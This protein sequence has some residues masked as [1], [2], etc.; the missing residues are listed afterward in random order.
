MAAACHVAQ[1]FG[2]EWRAYAARTDGA[3]ALRRWLS[4][5][6]GVAFILF[7]GGVELACGLHRQHVPRAILEL[8]AAQAAA[9]AQ[10]AADVAAVSTDK[11]AH[12]QE[13]GFS[14][15][16]DLLPAPP[17]SKQQRPK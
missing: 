13:H 9:H 3:R 8:R 1:A 2:D 14:A 12:L 5:P 17:R 15:G 11:R 6:G 10:A 4:E 7:A 16:A